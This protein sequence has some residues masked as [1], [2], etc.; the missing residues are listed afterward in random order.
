[1]LRFL[2]STIQVNLKRKGNI[3]NKMNNF[4]L[5]I[6]GYQIKSN[7]L[8]SRFNMVAFSLKVS[9]C[10]ILMLKRALWESVIRSFEKGRIFVLF[11]GNGSLFTKPCELMMTHEKNEVSLATQIFKMVARVDVLRNSVA[12]EYP[13]PISY[14]GFLFYFQATLCAVNNN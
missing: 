14:S 1:M 7:S 13:Y 4:I 5:L 11:K 6:E 10:V 2:H 12:A 8:K 9:C 3:S